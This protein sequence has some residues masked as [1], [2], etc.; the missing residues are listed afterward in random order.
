[1]N[2]KQILISGQGPIYSIHPITEGRKAGFIFM[3]YDWDFL[4]KKLEGDEWDAPWFWMEKNF[5][6]VMWKQMFNDL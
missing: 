2:L 5:I 6:I 4:N 1:M 3:E